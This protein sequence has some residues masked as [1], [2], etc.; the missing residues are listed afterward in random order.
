MSGL[1]ALV[2]WLTRRF[3]TRLDGALLIALGWL[4]GTRPRSLLTEV[5]VIA[6]FMTGAGVSS[7]ALRRLAR[8]QEDR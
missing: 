6:T 1:R 7:A 4:V 8:I 5:V 2:A 3:W